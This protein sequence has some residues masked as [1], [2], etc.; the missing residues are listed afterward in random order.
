M[1]FDAV[2][3]DLDG[4]LADTLDGIAGALNS[5]LEEF[6]LPTH[7]RDA[8]RRF[9]GNGVEK[10]VE[11]ALPADRHDLVG[12][13]LVRYLPVLME[14][15]GDKARAYDGAGRVLDEL[16][17]RGLPF[18]VLSNKPH[19]PTVDVVGRLFDRWT[20]AEVAG[21]QQ[22]VPIKPDPAAAWRLAEVMGVP[23]GRCAFVGDS[24]VDML[25][26][27]N[28]GMIGIGAAYGL[29]G[30]EELRDAGATH[31]ITQIEGVIDLL[32]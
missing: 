13:V 28:A 27:S 31:V 18:A 2:I 26:A 1:S 29:R 25:T 32:D 9:I 19:E 4:T 21:A 12:E 30:A 15:G 17:E 14:E 22:G 16:T 5:V 24:D 6:G 8:Y 23:A 10:L 7:D 20:F 3:F 11:R